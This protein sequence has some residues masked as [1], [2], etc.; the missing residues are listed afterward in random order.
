MSPERLAHLTSL[1]VMIRATARAN[2]A[3]R[4]E[5]NRSVLRRS[6]PKF[7]SHELVRST[8]HRMPRG[9]RFGLSAVPVLRRSAIMKSASPRSRH[10][11]RT[12]PL[13]YPRSRC[14]VSTS[15]SRPRSLMASR[16]G[17][18]RIQS[19]RLAPS[20]TQPMG[21]PLVS[22]ATDHF[23]PVLPRSVGFG[24]VPS[25]PAGALCCDPSIDTSDRSSPITLSKAAIASST[26]CSNAPAAT[27]SSRR[28]RSVVSLPLP[29][30]PATSHEQPVTRRKRMASKQSRSEIR[31]R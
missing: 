27:H 11:D 23:H 3:R 10:C 19:C 30:L 14:R 2:C 13:S 31:G 17:G 28:R 7:E 8:G 4:C 16:V 1:T 22:V 20:V 9:T 24:P 29:S 15:A 26:R 6:W 25:P 12:T 21:T 18:S 5:M